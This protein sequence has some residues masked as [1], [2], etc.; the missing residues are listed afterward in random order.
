M[1]KIFRWTFKKMITSVGCVHQNVFKDLINDLDKH[2][3]TVRKY[4]RE[5][6]ENKKIH[7]SYW[8]KEQ[9]Y[10]IKWQALLEAKVIFEV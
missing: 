10:I 9:Y 5:L 7:A 2:C 3:E 1:E 8:T 4:C 6:L